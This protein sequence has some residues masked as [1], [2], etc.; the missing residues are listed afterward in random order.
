MADTVEEEDNETATGLLTRAGFV[1]LAV[2]LLVLTFAMLYPRISHRIFMFLSKKKKPAE[3]AEAAMKRICKL[4]GIGSGCTSQE[5]V[6]LAAA[7]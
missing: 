3:T 2:T 5:A 6:P 1:I 7:K 4:Y